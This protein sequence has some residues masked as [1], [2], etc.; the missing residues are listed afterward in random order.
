[1]DGVGDEPRSSALERF[2][3]QLGRNYQH[4]LDRSTIYVKSRWG[5]LAVLL[6]LYLLR[7]YLLNGWFIVTYGL[8][9]FL[10]NLFIGFISPQI[11]PETDGPVLPTGKDGEFRPF[12]RRV[13]EFKF[14]LGS[15]NATI[16]ATLLTFFKMF[17][18]PVFWPI[19]LIYFISLFFLTMRRQISHMVKH[20]YVPWSSGKTRYN[21]KDPVNAPGSGEGKP[22][23]LSL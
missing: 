3:A 23:G 4:M 10:L 22:K 5:G 9:I 6:A 19:L 1:M 17:D 11:D 20:K 13:P 18:V 15:F 2:V 7:V 12:S 14:W 16:F 21:K 8:G